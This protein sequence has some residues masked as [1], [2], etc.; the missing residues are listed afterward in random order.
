MILSSPPLSNQTE[1]KQE[2]SLRACQPPQPPGPVPGVCRQPH[3]GVHSI[4][5]VRVWSEAPLSA[6]AM[7]SQLVALG[8]KDALPRAR[9]VAQVPL[10]GCHVLGQD[11]Q[12]LH[13]G[14]RA[15][16]YHFRDSLG[17]EHVRLHRLLLL[18]RGDT[19]HEDRHVLHVV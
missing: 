17:E 4:Y 3:A 8:H 5:T 6:A 9:R 11:D 10:A 1:S 7:E 19:H 13:D 15:N 12:S 14:L 18:R 2:R 16:S